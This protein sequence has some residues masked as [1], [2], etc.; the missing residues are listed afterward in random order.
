[1]GA[2]GASSL[3]GN[4]TN[5]KGAPASFSTQANGYLAVSVFESGSNTDV[6]NLTS[7]GGGSFFGTASASTLT[8]G[9]STITVNAYFVNASSQIVTVPSQV[10][11]TGKHDGTDIATIYDSPGT[12][13]LTASGSKATLS[14]SLDTMT[15]DKFGKVTVNKQSGSSDTEQQN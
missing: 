3:A 10:V 2:P 5:V 8:V 13:A 9:T 15:I 7:P 6:A 14:T 11:V 12:N 4:T 1:N